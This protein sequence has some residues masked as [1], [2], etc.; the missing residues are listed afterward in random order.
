MAVILCAQKLTGLIKDQTHTITEHTKRTQIILKA[1][2]IK[3]FG[4]EYTLK[5]QYPI[6]CLAQGEDAI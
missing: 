6:E 5:I 3:Q 4:A 2:L 1:L